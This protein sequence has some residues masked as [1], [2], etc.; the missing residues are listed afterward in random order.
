MDD[1]IQRILDGD[2]ESEG[3]SPA[4]RRELESYLA[5][6]TGTTDS[7]R[8]IDVPDLSERV[9]AEIE[10]IEANAGPSG[11]SHLRYILRWLWA[12]R[13]IALAWRPAYPVALI[14]L[15]TFVVAS[16]WGAQPR[17]ITAG[18]DNA[19]EPPPAA[20]FVQFR[21]DAPGA[22]SVEVTGSFTNWVQG[23]ELIETTP[24]IWSTLLPLE[25]GVHDYT[26]IVDG[27]IWV[28]DP[29]A[30]AIADGFGGSKN[31]LFLT[32]P[33]ENA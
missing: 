28:L 21:L 12:P 27:E 9:M 32:Q 33:L 31:R 16:I 11:M 30:P 19:S 26:F 8:A 18:I 13:P 10:Q 29:A 25:P 17:T 24:G 14:V 4:E 2:G 20:L 1:R 22:T 7:I 6:I 3:L 5:A 15:V 23:V